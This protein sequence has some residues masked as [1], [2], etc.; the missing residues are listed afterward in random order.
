MGKSRTSCL[1]SPPINSRFAPTKSWLLGKKPPIFTFPA[2]VHFEDLLSWDYKTPGSHQ[3]AVYSRWKF[4]SESTLVLDFFPSNR[5]PV[6]ANQRKQPS[7]GKSLHPRVKMA[8]LR[9]P[10]LASKGKMLAS[11]GNWLMCAKA[12]DT[13]LLKDDNEGRRSLSISIREL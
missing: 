5:L 13:L 2:N 3:P 6:G 8:T 9:H 11:K 1:Q 12:I 10:K 7:K 4:P